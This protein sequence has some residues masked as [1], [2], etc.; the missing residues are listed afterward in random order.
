MR[1]HGC[2]GSH[3][4]LPAVLVAKGAAGPGLFHHHVGPRDVQNSRQLRTTK[5]MPLRRV[6]NGHALLFLRHSKGSLLLHGE[7][8]LANDV[9]GAFPN[10]ITGLETFFQ[11]T[12]VDG[13]AEMCLLKVR[14]GFNGLI[15]RDDGT[16]IGP[17][18]LHRRCAAL[19]GAIG[20]GHHQSQLLTA[21]DDGPANLN[22]DGLF[23][24][25]KSSTVGSWNVRCSDD[26]HHTFDFQ[27]F[28]HIQILEFPRG[29]FAQDWIAK[30]GWHWLVIC[31]AYGSSGESHGRQLWFVVQAWRLLELQV[32]CFEW[33][34][35][36]ISQFFCCPRF[37][38]EMVLRLLKELEQV[39]VRQIA[40]V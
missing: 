26:I 33:L 4:H 39:T 25:G 6:P 8:M 30:E 5:V 20:C 32:S 3:R 17:G 31:V 34:H 14:S 16:F 24:C 36:E 9:S 12:L 27:G 29:H 19:R 15:D 13:V 23:S 11:I 40:A 18:D 2:H 21:G 35:R 10:H 7:S 37:D 38:S 1:R 28:R 22:K